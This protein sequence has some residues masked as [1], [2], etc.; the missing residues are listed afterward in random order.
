MLL[1]LI[2][3]VGGH[4]RDVAHLFHL[5]HSGVGLSTPQ[6]LFY[7][8]PAER[9]LWHWAD[10]YS[11]NSTDHG[12]PLSVAHTK[13]TNSLAAKL[14]STH[15]SATGEEESVL[16]HINTDHT[17]RDMLS[18]MRAHGKEKLSYW[19]FSYGTVLG[20]TFASMFPVSLACLSRRT[21]I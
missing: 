6:A 7:T 11:I 15:R 18:I 8:T 13:V 4:I 2:L 1:V 5:D 21:R 9:A 17:A 10:L 20:A 19:G 16:A 3:E 12:V 14:D